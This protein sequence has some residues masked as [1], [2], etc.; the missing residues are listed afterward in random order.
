[1]AVYV[2]VNTTTNG[3]NYTTPGDV[4]DPCKSGLWTLNKGSAGL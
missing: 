1:M 3:P 4:T 2:A